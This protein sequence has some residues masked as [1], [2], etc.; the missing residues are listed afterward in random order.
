MARRVNICARGCIENRARRGASIGRFKHRRCGMARVAR[1][2]A[3]AAAQ[4]AA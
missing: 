4:Q 2:I 3:V 1:T